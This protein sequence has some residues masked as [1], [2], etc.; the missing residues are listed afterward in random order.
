[1]RKRHNRGLTLVEM[2]VTSTLGL[3]L[4][5]SIMG[6]LT[7]GRLVWQDAEAKMSTIQEARKGV[8]EIALD[9]PRSS[10]RPPGSGG[11]P[12][13]VRIA[14]DGSWIRFYLP[15][16]IDANG[17]ITWGDEIRY[18]VGGTGNQLVRE[19]LTSGEARVIANFITSVTFTR[20]G[21]VPEEYYTA[22]IRSQK[23]S[24][25]TRLFDTT[26]QTNIAMRN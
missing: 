2:M 13:V 7:L 15:R 1:M 14:T 10:S 4:L 18:R 20:S 5:A 22:S 24:L 26:L 3:L 12:N 23:N 25:T 21:T 8:T 17:N 11:P 19:N 16:S 9:L 6:L